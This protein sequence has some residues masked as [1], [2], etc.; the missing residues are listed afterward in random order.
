[1]FNVYRLLQ[2]C[3]LHQTAHTKVISVLLDQGYSTNAHKRWALNIQINRENAYRSCSYLRVLSRTIYFSLLDLVQ[4]NCQF[5]ILSRSLVPF[6]IIYHL[7]P[8][9]F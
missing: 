4:H 3:Q 6:I 5:S 2:S 8:F 7:L 9:L 1:M